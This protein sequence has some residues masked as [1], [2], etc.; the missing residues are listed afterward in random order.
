MD[1]TKIGAM[2]RSLRLEKEMTQSDLANKLNVSN[3]TISK[4][5]CGLGCPDI[6]LIS[7]LSDILGVD[8]SHMLKGSLSSNDFV[9][10]NMKNSTFYICPACGN[11]SVHSGQAQTI[12]CGRRVEEQP[13][14][15]ANDS[16]QLD[17]CVDDDEWHITSSHPMDK[18]NY[19][20]F[21]AF[22]T[23]GSMQLI[24]LYPEWDL[25]I[26]IARQ[27]HGKLVWFSTTKGL[28]YQFV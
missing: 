16:E 2:I 9:G 8:I 4:W 10:G 21:V 25:S 20:S 11:I 5:E 17:V 27:G 13:Q 19:I 26:R 7:E 24:K 3:K 12:C 1:C 14:Q 22:L 18:D 6:S 15:K 28:F 23:G